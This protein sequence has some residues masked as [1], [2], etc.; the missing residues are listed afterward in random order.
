MDQ[1]YAANPLRYP[2]T[3]SEQSQDWVR[4]QFIHQVTAA[5]RWSSDI[6]RSKLLCNRRHANALPTI[7]MRG[8]GHDV[9]STSR[10]AMLGGVAS[11]DA[12]RR[13]ISDLT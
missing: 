3:L 11:L 10:L 5:W 13:G 4:T 7:S 8:A 12:R 9:G 2:N 1:G 6:P